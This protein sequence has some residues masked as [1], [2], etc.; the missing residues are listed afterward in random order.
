MW[1][2]I[3]QTH[4]V[5]LLGSDID[6]VDVNGARQSGTKAQPRS[7]LLKAVQPL[8]DQPV[9]PS[10]HLECARD[11]AK[12]VF[13]RGGKNKGRRERGSVAGNAFTAW[14]RE[15]EEVLFEFSFSDWMCGG[16]KKIR[17]LI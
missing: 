3:S 4:L 2:I 5:T 12:P 15:D 13:P 17:E 1:A 9:D 6:A 16:Q 7:A 8:P 11:Q 14:I 10:L